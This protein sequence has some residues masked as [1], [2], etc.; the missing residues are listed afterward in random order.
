MFRFKTMEIEGCYLITP[1]VQMDNTCDLIKF[2]ND[3]QF[4]IY[5]V[6]TE[7]KEE[8]YTI[9]KPGVIRGMH[10]QKEPYDH[11]KI[12]TCL[13]GDIQ[14]VIVDLREDSKSY[15]KF[16]MVDLNDKNKNMIYIPKGCAHGYYIRGNKE[17]LVFYK[18]TKPYY[19]D[20]RAGIHWDSLNIPWDFRNKFEVEVEEEDKILP[21]IN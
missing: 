14:D 2:F 15:K 6:S 12:V 16:T 11:C 4:N 1:T 20:Y 3:E 5:G 17:A 21:I 8:Y 9:A 18:V 10:Y 13:S 7:F 19:K